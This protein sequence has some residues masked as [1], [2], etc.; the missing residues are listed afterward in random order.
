MGIST[1]RVSWWE[2]SGS[3]TCT[4]TGNVPSQGRPLFWICT[5]I[6]SGW[7]NRWRSRTSK[8]GYTNPEMPWMVISPSLSSCTDPSCDSTTT[9]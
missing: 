1:R 6:R 9:V 8:S 4:R 7:I 5:V 2:E 3:Q